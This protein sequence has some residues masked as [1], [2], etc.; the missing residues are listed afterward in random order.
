MALKEFPDDIARS[1]VEGGEQGCRT[2]PCVSRR[3]SL[4]MRWHHGKQRLRAVQRLNLRLLI[5]TEHNGIVRGRHVQADDVAY[6][7]D[8]LRVL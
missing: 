7:L 3:A 2:V 4:R 6:L 8:E 1:H 5:D